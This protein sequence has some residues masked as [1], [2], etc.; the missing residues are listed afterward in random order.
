MK[1]SLSKLKNL[2]HNFIDIYVSFSYTL[3]KYIWY[4]K[5]TYKVVTLYVKES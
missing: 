4:E 1:L 3:I 2:N 5:I